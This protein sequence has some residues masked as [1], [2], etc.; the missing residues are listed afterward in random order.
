MF[1]VRLA[2]DREECQRLCR[3]PA[4]EFGPRPPEPR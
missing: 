2:V 1:K 4:S 3:H